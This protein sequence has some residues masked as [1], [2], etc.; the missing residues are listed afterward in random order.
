M[1]EETMLDIAGATKWFNNHGYPYS[2]RQVQRMATNHRC[3]FR[4]GPDGKKLWVP[5]SALEEFL[6]P[7]QI[8]DQ[9]QNE[10]RV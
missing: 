5:L 8:G 10:P 1:T 3:G 7:G 2:Y 6:K 4:L 9:P